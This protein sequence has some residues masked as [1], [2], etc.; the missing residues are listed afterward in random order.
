MRPASATL[1]GASPSSYRFHIP[2][3]HGAWWSFFSTLVGALIVALRW[4]ADGA[5]CL[6]AAL[7]LSAG[8]LAQDWAQSLLG[9][10]LRRPS[11]AVSQWQ[12]WQGWV[13]A[14]AASACAAAQLGLVPRD[15]WLPWSALLGLLALASGLGLAARVLSKG[16]GRQ[17][18]AA[19]A[20]LLA[21]PALWLGVLAFHFSPK[22]LA[23][24][25]WP[26]AFYP[27]ATLSAQSFIRGFPQRARWLGP[28]LALLLGALA[29]GLGAWP[30]GA[31]LMLQ[32]WRLHG[33]IKR[34]WRET[35]AGLPPGG[36]IRAFGREQ[37]FF[38]VTLTILWV[39][40]FIQP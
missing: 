8:F 11:Q 26:L 15:R 21:S 5:A 22:A 24:W 3:E 14:L 29:L 28:A 17:S 18:L 2:F 13:L 37:A 38:G 7:A 27:V 1:A 33:A 6:V 19:T 9:A 12:A 31:V 16:R 35:P 36:A 30:A 40:A 32:A 4:G 10:L 20:L 23:L 39:L 34:R 25:A